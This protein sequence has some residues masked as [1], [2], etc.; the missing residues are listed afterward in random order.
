MS[1]E[2]RDNQEFDTINLNKLGNKIELD[3]FVDELER[4]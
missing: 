3:E 2:V 4:F 1:G